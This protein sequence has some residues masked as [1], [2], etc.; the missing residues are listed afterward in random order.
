MTETLS[1]GETVVFWVLGPIALAGALGMVLSRNAVHSALWLV[2]T[3]LALGVFYVV[4]EAPFLGAVQIIVYTGAIMIL[5]LFV[6]MLVG[7]DS[8][9]SVVETLR[10]QW[11]A[12]ILLGL[13]FAGLVG[14]GVARATQGLPVTGLAGVQGGETSNIEA[15]A[16]LL[17]TRYLLAFEVTSALLIT[18]AIGAMVLTH[19][20]RTVRRPSQR[21]L[22][23]ERFAGTHPTPLPGPGVFARHDAVDT[24]APLPDGTEAPGSVS[25]VLERSEP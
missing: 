10:G 20:E 15:I 18:A 9:D 16:Q 6:L 11:V 14:A 24:P 17:F 5:F 22:S 25:P 13:G 23:R 1:G 2:N 4:Q 21:E 12:A 8:S 19:K 3:M 7:R